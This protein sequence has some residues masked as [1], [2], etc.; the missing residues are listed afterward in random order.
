MEFGPVLE[1]VASVFA[2]LIAL[3]VV[4]ERGL[5]TLFNWKYYAKYVGGKGLKVPISWGVSFLIAKEV[6]VDL[7]AMLFNGDA[8][9]LGQV[10]TA[11]LL[12]GGSKKVAETFGDLKKAA[13]ELR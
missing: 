3:S 2:L 5:A 9:V 6:P 4:I 10:L 13:E 11:G 7:V 12:A 8:T 1:N